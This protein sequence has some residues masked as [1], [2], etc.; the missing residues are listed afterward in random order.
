MHAESM[1]HG[2][3]VEILFQSICLGVVNTQRFTLGLT[4]FL[5]QRKH[6]DLIKWQ[7]DCSLLKLAFYV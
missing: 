6:L 3:G 2:G 1:R 4:E 7:W 5:L